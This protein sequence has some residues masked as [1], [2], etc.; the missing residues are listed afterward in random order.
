[1]IGVLRFIG[2]IN[3]A[4]WL[5]GTV[6]FVLFAEPAIFS[7]AMFSLL[8]AKNFPYFSE[9]IAQIIASN[10]YYF[11]FICAVIAVLQ[12]LAEWLY[13][14]RPGRKVSFGI[15]VGLLV[16][17]LI[18][19]HVVLP[20]LKAFH[21]ERHQVN[22]PPAEREAAARSFNA[23]R[24]ADRLLDLC[25]IGGLIVFV[26]RAANPSDTLRFVG[27]VKFREDR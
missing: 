14:G 22:V 20:K 6:F 7:R 24:I 2:L 10:Y 19:N 23:W 13:L 15:L 3:A 27:S 18:G 26:W 4:I 9:A 8:E 25:M 5:G 12:Q 1:V 16:L 17:G 21:K 11:H